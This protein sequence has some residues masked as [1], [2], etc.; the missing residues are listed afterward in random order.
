MQP[1]EN[2][3]TPVSSGKAETEKNKKHSQADQDIRDKLNPR[4]YGK[5]YTKGVQVDTH[6]VSYM[7]TGLLDI[8][9][10]IDRTRLQ[11]DWRL[12]NHSWAH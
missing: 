4:Q 5:K 2:E 9:V 8:N 11:D 10:E 1:R 12:Q 7:E 3:I 6:K